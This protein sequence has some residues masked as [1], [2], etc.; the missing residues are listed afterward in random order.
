MASDLT[1]TENA[2]PALMAVSLA[3]NLLKWVEHSSSSGT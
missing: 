1:L 2:Q 3:D